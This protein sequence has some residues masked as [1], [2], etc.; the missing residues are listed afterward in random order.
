MGRSHPD[1]SGPNNLEMCSW[2]ISR[3]HF[4]WVGNIKMKKLFI[5]VGQYQDHKTVQLEIVNVTKRLV[6][7][8][9]EGKPR[10]ELLENRMLLLKI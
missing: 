6:G 8:Y 7:N 10:L 5:L 9:E 2:A 1:L 4:D 3:Q